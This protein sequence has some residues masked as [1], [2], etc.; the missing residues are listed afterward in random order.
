MWRAI[1]RIPSSSLQAYFD[2]LRSEHTDKSLQATLNSLAFLGGLERAQAQAKKGVE[3][4]Y[5]TNEKEWKRVDDQFIGRETDDVS[6][7]QEA[8]QGVSFSIPHSGPRSYRFVQ[9]RSSK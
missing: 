8:P 1:T 5:D 3:M 6:R 9:Y 2:H 4:D 7:D